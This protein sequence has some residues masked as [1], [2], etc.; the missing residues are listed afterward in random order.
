MIKFSS[1]K[2][3]YQFVLERADDFIDRLKNSMKFNGFYIFLSLL[4]PLL[5]FAMGA[6]EEIFLILLNRHQF[7]NNVLIDLSFF[8]LAYCL[9]IVPALSI[10][11]FRRNIFGRNYTIQ[12]EELAFHKLAKIYNGIKTSRFTKKQI[13]IRYLAT[14]PFLFFILGMIYNGID[15]GIMA[16]MGKIWTI[17]FTITFFILF[18]ILYYRGSE[19]IVN[20]IY[21]KR[22]IKIKLIILYIITV[23]LYSFTINYSQIT[24]QNSTFNSSYFFNKNVD[25]NPILLIISHSFAFFLSY[26]ILRSFELNPTQKTYTEYYSNGKRKHKFLL[27]FLTA[28]L[29]IFGILN[30]YGILGILSPIVVGIFLIAFMIMVIEAFVTAPSLLINL[31]PAN[32]KNGMKRIT[33][34][35]VLLF[36]MGIFI[37]NFFSNFNRYEIRTI[38][39]P[40]QQY[41]RQDLETYFQKWIAE[42]SEGKKEGDTIKVYLVSGQGGGSRAGAWFLM[43]MLN[44]D[45]NDPDF[46]KNTISLSTVSG[47]TSGANMF[48]AIQ[49]L[50]QKFEKDTTLYRKLEP[51]E[52]T[53]SIYN[54]NFVNGSLYGLLVTDLV[55]GFDRNTTLQLE[56]RK[57]LQNF[58][59]GENAA[60]KSK[61]I[62]NFFESDY[63]D[64]YK[65]GSTKTPL[66]FINSTV[67]TTGIKAIFSPVKLKNSQ[68]ER[69]PQ[70]F[71]AIDL[72][73]NFNKY[74]NKNRKYNLPLITCV[75]QSQ[76]FP[77]ANSYNYLESVGRLS[78]GGAIE[79]TGIATSVELYKKLLQYREK[80]EQ[81]SPVKIKFVF[82]NILNSKVFEA[83][84]V[85]FQKS[86]LTD[87]LT[88]V[89]NSIF[90]ASQ[91]IAVQNQKD[92]IN[93]SKIDAFFDV[94]LEENVA[95]TRLLS[96]K[97]IARMYKKMVPIK[98]SK[99]NDE[100]IIKDLPLVYIQTNPANRNK[101]KKLN[102]KNLMDS[103]SFNVKFDESVSGISIAEN[104]IRYFN[105]EDKEIAENLQKT[106]SKRMGETITI[107]DLSETNDGSRVPLQQVEVWIKDKNSS[108]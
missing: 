60:E 22:N 52:I 37:F 18:L 39:N 100:P 67:A 69:T 105:K 64:M 81:Q 42:R 11:F 89:T 43:N 15:A 80:F 19:Y 84:P 98:L 29:I 104:E 12:D 91:P 68:N 24:D 55:N 50:K 99:G 57:A 32:E 74:K 40:Q 78:D 5:L 95:L 9:W 21:E 71:S 97:T 94:Q 49:H 108:K 75:N 38:V 61:I 63:M 93:K 14:L 96:N 10:Y 8:M 28:S 85:P 87:I 88:Q 82:I 41:E 56:E 2:K 4:F 102:S 77:L 16:K 33:L 44:F 58:F 30:A 54:K 36:A 103:T 17:I 72:Y 79:N 73:A 1:L 20:K 48:L 62:N 45:R 53:K 86:S 65:N 26:F 66:F 7:I 46:Y 23:L 3:W 83:A 47:S 35:F 106:I 6:G 31:F 25:I 51:F 34:K 59:A 90:N 76:A 101:L 27:I 13:A 107:K 70:I 92:A